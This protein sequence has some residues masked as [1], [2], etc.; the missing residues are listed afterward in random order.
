MAAAG[1]RGAA[2]GA[3]GGAVGGAGATGAGA[4][5]SG[6]GGRVV[7]GDI[8]GTNAR[9]QLWGGGG[10]HS[11]GAQRTYPTSDFPS[12]QACL[13]AFLGEFSPGEA[14]AVA[15]FA[16]AGPVSDHALCAMTNISWELDAR[17]LEREG[18]VGQCR[19]LNDFEAIGYGV[20]AV[21]SEHLVSLHE[22]ARVERGPILVLGPG[23]GFGQALLLW[24]AGWGRYRVYPSEGSHADF[25]P[26]GWKQRA[27]AQ[28]VENELGYCEAEHVCCGTGLVRIYEFLRSGHAGPMGDSAP[29]SL[30]DGA[31]VT[32][33]A[34]SGGCPLAQEACDIFLA[35]VG[36]EAGNGALRTLARG[37][38]YVCG[39]ITPRLLERVKA[40]G[41]RSAFLHKGSRFAPFLETIPVDLVTDGAVG[42]LGSREY[43]RTVEDEL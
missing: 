16:A 30:K 11:P 1:R 3:A 6:R 13:Q 12:F 33:A 21:A 42:M 37:G 36:Q 14:P 7:V 5:I 4:G 25:A 39:G 28:H 9:L 18:L 32:S 10:G 43:A 38:V 35:I 2:G 19:I 20:G 8:G 29:P 41:L 24:D 40:G 22:G 26:R 17:S 15:V 31:G 23:T 34:L 27:L